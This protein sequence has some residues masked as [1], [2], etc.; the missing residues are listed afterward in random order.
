MP[1]GQMRT[2][3]MRYR[4]SI[5]WA[6]FGLLTTL[7]FGE[8]V[9]RE[10]GIVDVP[11][12]AVDDEIGYVPT[13]NQHGCFLN[14]NCW[15][16]NDRSMG[17]AIAWN[18]KLHP[19]VLLIGNSIVMGGDHFDQPDKLG[20]LVQQKVGLG[21]SVWPIA[22]NG[23]S[24]P[25]ECVYFERH[26]EVL[27]ETNFFVW[28]VMAGGLGQLS[29]WPG[30]YVL[31]VEHPSWALWYALCR[32]IL[33]R[34]FDVHLTALPPKRTAAPYYVGQFEAMLAKMSRA[35]G[36]VQP[37]ILFLYPEEAELRSARQGREWLPERQELERLSQKWG[38]RIVDVSQYPEWT[39]AQYRDGTHPTVSGN[40]VLADILGAA[41][42]D[43]LQQEPTH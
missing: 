4:R 15:V 29:T 42:K 34:L 19:N 10:S 28:E 26:P 35:T 25:N 5:K 33:S 30:K 21:Y 9:V 7:V 32:F 37:G 38:L 23:W 11:T 6:F 17:T 24:N 18:P 13:P 22:S 3:F 14:K 40:R 31:P 41:I 16:F 2:E 43:S 8:I 27:S 20:P 12:F 1:A 39:E 36:R